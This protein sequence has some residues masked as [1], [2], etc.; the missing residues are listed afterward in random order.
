LL[1]FTFEAGTAAGA[2]WV[3]SAETEESRTAM[4]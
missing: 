1:S 2:F 4:V 3:K